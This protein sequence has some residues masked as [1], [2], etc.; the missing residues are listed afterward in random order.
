MTP[1]GK[2][3]VPV[4]GTPVQFVA[5]PPAGIQPVKANSIYV[6]VWKANTGFVYIGKAG[7]VKATGVGV[8]A[9]LPIPT[10][11]SI[12]EWSN[13][14]PGCPDPFALQ[15]LWV[16]ADVAGDAVLVSFNCW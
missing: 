6:Q 10:M 2:I 16:D 12:P 7:M 9:Q 15:D 4:P 3:V 13:V 1:L 5:P 8:L 14:I 11:T